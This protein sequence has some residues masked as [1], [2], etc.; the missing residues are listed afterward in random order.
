M[1]Q[2]IIQ[3]I[4]NDLQIQNKQ[5]EQT[6]TL[7]EEGCTVP[8]IARYRK[9]RTQGLDEEQIRVIQENYAYSYRLEI[10]NEKLPFDMSDSNKIDSVRGMAMTIINSKLN[11]KED[12][13]YLD[14]S[15]TAFARQTNISDKDKITG[16]IIIYDKKTG[17]LVKEISADQISVAGT[18][19]LNIAIDKGYEVTYGLTN[20][21]IDLS[22]LKPGQYLFLYDASFEADN[23]VQSGIVELSGLFNQVDLANGNYTYSLYQ[24]AIRNRMELTINYINDEKSKEIDEV[25]DDVASDD[26]KI[27]EEQIQEHYVLN[28]GQEANKSN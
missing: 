3:Q 24:T 25:A 22:D 17:K 10:S 5:V 19:G 8:F 23:K 20:T 7:L 26:G 14:L 12:K 16:R 15:F 9:E 21:S 11:L 2:A 27:S 1:E 4:A 28:V 13:P 18:D 6:L